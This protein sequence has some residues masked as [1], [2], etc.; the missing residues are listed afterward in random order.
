M[1]HGIFVTGHGSKTGFG[2]GGTSLWWGGQ[3]IWVYY[4]K[5]QKKLKYDLGAVIMHVCWG[6]SAFGASGLVS[7]DGIHYG[8][9]RIFY[10]L[11]DEAMFTGRVSED[12]IM[13][14][15]GAYYERLKNE[16]QLEECKV[17]P[18]SS[19]AKLIAKIFG[20]PI[21]IVGLLMVSFMLSS[22]VCSIVSVITD[23]N[24]GF[25]IFSIFA[26]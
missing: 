21:L 3:K 8:V 10:P 12:H 13:H 11:V 25:D 6:G 1:L 26:F 23:L 20:I 9:N 4:T 2:T 22:L 18:A 15:R 19:G 16:D 5:I 17:K 7:P 24:I 14:E